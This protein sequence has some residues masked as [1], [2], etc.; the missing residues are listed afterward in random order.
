MPNYFKNQPTDIHF[1][2]L[3]EICKLRKKMGHQ[4]EIISLYSNP[5]TNDKF[6]MNF[7]LKLGS[8]PN[9]TAKIML[10]Y[11]EAVIKLKNKK[12]FGSYTPLDIPV[13]FLFSEKEKD[14]LFDLC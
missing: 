8:N 7:K 9:F 14:I 2:S 4:G 1:V 12:H 10:A 13:S 11:I 3:N 5:S 6:Y